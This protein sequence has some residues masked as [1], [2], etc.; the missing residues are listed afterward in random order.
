MITLI[1][2]C[3]LL[4]VIY[5]SCYKHCKP[6]EVIVKYGKTIEIL[7]HRTFVIPIFQHYKKLSLK[8]FEVFEFVKCYTHDFSYVTVK[9]SCIVAISNVKAITSLFDME[10]VDIHRILLEIIKDSSS[11]FVK[12]YTIS[13]LKE[14]NSTKPLEDKIIKDFSNFGISVLSISSHVNSQ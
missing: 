14:S 6:N 10:L 13:K 8:P 11:S 5:L 1:L 12:D 7:H 2:V 3:I 4:F 9:V